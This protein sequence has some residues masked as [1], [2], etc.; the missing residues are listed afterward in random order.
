[1]RDLYVDAVTRVPPDAGPAVVGI[2]RASWSRFVPT[3]L[4]GARRPAPGAW[5]PAPEGGAVA[6]EHVRGHRSRNGRQRLAAALCPFASS[7]SNASER[8]DPLCTRAEWR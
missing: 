2:K 8:N 5:R 7:G 1:M 6:P 4:G 3:L